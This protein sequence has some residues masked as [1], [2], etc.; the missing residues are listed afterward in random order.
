MSNTNYTYE[1]L[2]NM[3]P[4]QLEEVLQHGVKPDL[5][6]MVGWTFRGWNVLMPIAKPVM[7]PLGFGRFAKGFYQLPGEKKPSEGGRVLGFNIKVSPGKLDEPWEAQ[8]NEE[9]PKRHGYYVVHPA[10][11][12]DRWHDK[13][14]NALYLN[15]GERADLNKLFDGGAL[16][17]DGGIRDY[18]VQVDP[19]NPDLFLGKA[20]YAVPPLR[21]EAGFFIAER[22][23][24]HSFTE[25]GVEDGALG[26]AA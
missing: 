24:R 3:K 22:L 7:A 19:E 18:M 16:Y 10:G 12:G 17:G 4:K 2:A 20:Y 26:K 13:Y 21:V 15:Y 9:N 25:P 11:E 5:D 14:P 6:S 8:P 23:K 1:M